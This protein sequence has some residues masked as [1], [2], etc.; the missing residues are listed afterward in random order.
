MPSNEY[1]ILQEEV[2]FPVVPR[3]NIRKMHVEMPS[4]RT[5]DFFIQVNKPFCMILAVQGAM[6]LCIEQFRVSMKRRSIEFVAGGIEDGE[7]PV[8]SA[9]RELREETGYQASKF[10]PINTFFAANG[11]SRLEGHIFLAES[12]TFVGEERDEHEE[13]METRWI[14]LAEFEDMIRDGTIQDGKTI[15]AYTYWKLDRSS[16]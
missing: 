9:Q 4:G 14:P 6:F 1:R 16:D 7:S 11:S 8:Q 3:W 5:R 13:R 10:T 12:L 2:V 15:A